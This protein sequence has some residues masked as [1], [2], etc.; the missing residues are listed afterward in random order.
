MKCISCDPVAVCNGARC[1]EGLDQF[2]GKEA[3]FLRKVLGTG[4]IASLGGIARLL[5]KPSNFFLQVILRST[6]FSAVGLLKIFFGNG[7]VFVRLALVICLFFRRKLRRNLWR[8]RMRGL[9]CRR[10]GCRLCNRPGWLCRFGAGNDYRRGCSGCIWYGRGGLQSLG[11]R[12]CICIR[13]NIH[14][15][16]RFCGGRRRSSSDGGRGLYFIPRTACEGK[17]QAAGNECSDK[18]SF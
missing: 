9:V 1:S 12:R 6:C 13:G 14:G 2:N 8:R 15:P 7:Q 11:R 16:L 10:L 18:S 5:N 4:E 3:G 17:R